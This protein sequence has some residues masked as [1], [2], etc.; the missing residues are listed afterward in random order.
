MGLGQFDGGEL[1]LAQKIA[2]LRKGERGELTH[3]R[4]RLLAAETRRERGRLARSPYLSLL[5]GGGRR[6]ACDRGRLARS[7]KRAQRQG[8]GIVFKGGRDARAPRSRHFH[9]GEPQRVHFARKAHQRT[10]RSA[11]GS[12]SQLKWR[13]SRIVTGRMSIAHGAAATF[14]AGRH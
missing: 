2:R 10:F 14:W 12:S 4:A 9:F 11:G 3:L 13:T 6:A 5:A 8:S 1:A 7:F